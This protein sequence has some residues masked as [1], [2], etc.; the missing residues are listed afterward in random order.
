MVVFDDE[1]QKRKVDDLKAREEEE[2]VQFLA[3][4]KYNL[5]YIDLS[6]TTIETSALRHITEDEA[7]KNSIAPFNI[8]GT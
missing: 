8:L 6:S 4:S 1:K 2:L 3:Q 5:P 7:R